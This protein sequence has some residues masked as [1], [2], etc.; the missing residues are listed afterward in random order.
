EKEIRE[1]PRQL[2]NQPKP[3]ESWFEV[4]VALELLRRG[5][6]VIPQYEVSGYRI[7]LV[8]EGDV[9]RLAVECDGDEWHGLERFDYDIARQRQLERAGWKFVRIRASEFYANRNRAVE[10]IEEA[11]R[12]LDIH[13]ARGKKLEWH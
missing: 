4:D 13:P 6:R 8:I 2:G 3:Y 10:L 1:R 5:Y 9:N 7:D 11:C 12:K